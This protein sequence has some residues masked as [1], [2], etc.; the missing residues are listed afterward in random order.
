MGRVVTVAGRGTCAVTEKPRVCFLINSLEGGGAE[1][2]MTNLLRHLGPHLGAYD[3]ELVLLDTESIAQDVPK[4]VRV[5]ELDG[6]K[7]LFRSFRQLS[8]HWSNGNAPDLCISY[9][10]RSNVL[11]VWLQRRFRHRAV[12]SERVQ[13]TGHLENARLGFVTRALV[14]LTYRHAARII[15]VSTGVADD[16]ARNFAVPRAKQ[17]VIGNPVDLDMIR[18][19]AAEANQITVPEQYI[20]AMGRMVKSKNFAFLL[21]A[22]AR[23]PD[24]PDLVI[25]GQG[26][27]EGPLREQ[28]RTLGIEGKVH[29]P[30]FVN[31]PYPTIVGAAFV[32][33][34]S[35]AEGF[36]NTIVE[37]L[38]LC[39]PVVSTD[40][41]AGPA[42]VLRENGD[43]GILVPESDAEALADGMARMLLPDVRDHYTARARERAK[44][45]EVDSVIAEYLSIIRKELVSSPP[46]I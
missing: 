33:S 46:R 44:A 6:R 37:A 29:M 22:Y 21:D 23:L 10:T 40:C 30:G 34:T 43:Y 39:I 1:R 2:A 38:C 27:L 24:A 42:Q 14:R 7:A 35:L 11:N 3:V 36:P 12:I 18:Q 45:F 25:L 28:A 26:P 16:L 4:W 20:L 15:A 19:R 41:A 17:V 31:N 13:T 8:V 32:V 9:L 5:T